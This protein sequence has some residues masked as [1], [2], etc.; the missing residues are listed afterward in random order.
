MADDSDQ[1]KRLEQR[2]DRLE[3][4]EAIKELRYEYCYAVDTFDEERF[5]SLFT[6]DA[7][8]EFKEPHSSKYE[9][10]E[11]LR[12]FF[13]AIEENRRFL[14]HLVH[15]PIIEVEGETATGTWYY[16][17]PTVDSNGEAF[18]LQ[19]RYDEQYRF[20]AGNWKFDR[21][22][23]SYAYEAPYDHGWADYLIQDTE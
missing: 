11:E 15:N 19:G 10:Q 8:V 6:T 3:A 13:R 12:S 16:E 18:W 9:R 22:E 7:T 23:A 4:K 14:A 17:V 20:V 5:L 21:I 1:L 2:L